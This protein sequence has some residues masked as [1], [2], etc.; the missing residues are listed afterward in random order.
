MLTNSVVCMDTLSAA[1]KD[2]T[3][4]RGVPVRSKDNGRIFLVAGIMK[5]LTGFELCVVII[6]DQVFYSYC[7]VL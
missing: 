6:V 5:P 7:A 2:I 3:L 1:K 4:S